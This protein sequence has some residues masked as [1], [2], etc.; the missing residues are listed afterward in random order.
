MPEV[1]PDAAGR[2]RSR[3]FETLTVEE[4]RRLSGRR[5]ADCLSAL[6]SV[7]VKP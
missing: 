4:N 3:I 2:P 5:G 7:S 1:L 6:V